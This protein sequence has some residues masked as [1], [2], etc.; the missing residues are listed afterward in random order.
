MIKSY[1]IFLSFFLLTQQNREE[2]LIKGA[3]I[4]EGCSTCQWVFKDGK[5]YRYYD[6]E[7]KF[8]YNYEI[9]EGKSVNGRF[10]FSFLK[11]TDTSNPNRIFEYEINA[12]GEE[13]MALEYLGG[14]RSASGLSIFTKKAIAPN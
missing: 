9:Y 13:K 10:T 11:L 8:T 7:L 2:E 1:L 4:P 6:G 14:T 12:L 3:W 5:C